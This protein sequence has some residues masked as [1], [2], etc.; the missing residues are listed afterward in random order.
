VFDAATAAKARDADVLL[1]DSAGRLHTK[2]ALM[3]E[4]IKIKR[5]IGRAVPGAPHEILLVLDAVTGQNGLA[6]AR[7]FHEPWGDGTVPALENA[8]GGSPAI[9]ETRFRSN[10]WGWARK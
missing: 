2:H 1:I 8:R 3:D 6:Q 10:S 9:M 7:V 4:L 5:V